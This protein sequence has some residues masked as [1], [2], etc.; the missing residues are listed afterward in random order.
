MKNLLL[1]MMVASIVLAGG[2]G[3]GSSHSHSSNDKPVAHMVY[4]TLIDDSQ[5][6][7]DDLVEGCYQYL[8][9]HRGVI[10][11]GAGARAEELDQDINDR[12]FHVGLHMVFR[13]QEHID[14]YLN[15][16]RHLKFVDLFK[17]NWQQVRVFDAFV[18]P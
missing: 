6:A 15:N 3:L 8:T 14:P 18:R 9:N 10:Y 1:S 4:F 13:S 7:K 11:F 5:A 2:C 16:S 17:D 12:D